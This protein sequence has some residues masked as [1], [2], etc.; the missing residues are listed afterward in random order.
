M[1]NAHQRYYLRKERIKK[2]VRGDAERPRLSVYRSLNQV[3]AQIID[4]GSGKIRIEDIR[5]SI[6]I[7]DGS[8]SIQIDEIKGDV[9]VTDG[10]GSILI[11]HVDGNVTL[12]DYSGSI[13]I[14]DITKNVFIR[15]TGT[16]ELEIDRVKGKIT[17]H[18]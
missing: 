6:D 14:S 8:G 7:K 15:Q 10:S 9:R 2:K 12:A 1:K 3:Y 13:D 4:D 11:Q 16:G 5:G 17:T 18:D